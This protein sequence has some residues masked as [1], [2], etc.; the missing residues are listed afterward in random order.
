L[1]PLRA[2]STPLATS[3]NK[4]KPRESGYMSSTEVVADGGG[5]CSSC[6]CL[7]AQ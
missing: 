4:F 5:E 1:P 6:E 7:E 3:S 2:S